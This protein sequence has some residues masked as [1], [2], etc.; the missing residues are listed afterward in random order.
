MGRMKHWNF[1]IMNNIVEDL[2]LGYSPLLCKIIF[3]DDEDY[4][5]FFDRLCTYYSNCNE[6]D[7]LQL[8]ILREFYD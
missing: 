7:Y 3:S 8:F 4:G 5:Y 6:W 1:L 2:E